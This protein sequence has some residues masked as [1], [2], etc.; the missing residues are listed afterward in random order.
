MATKKTIAFDLETIADSTV[1][2]FLPEVEPDTRLKDPEKIKASIAEKTVKRD[3]ELGLNPATS[4]I[5]CFGYATAEGTGHIML[6]DEQSEKALLV[7][8]WDLLAKFDHF[9][10]FNGI[11]FDV[12][13]LMFHSLKNR[14]RPAVKISIKKYVI[15]NHT[16]VRAVLGNW[17]GF[18]KGK[19]DFFAKMLLGG[20]GKDGM[21]GDQVQGYWDMDL[22]D[23]IAA[24]CESDC[25]L[26]RDIFELM[27]KYY[28]L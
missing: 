20:S 23:D 14:I 21:T 9:V 2:P 15:E 8:A 13:T 28:L 1:I 6:K 17:D 27:Q 18:A 5:C 26:T 4:L 22:K 10:T 25:R 16:D 3:A 11:S 7:E 24:Y 19:L 12:P